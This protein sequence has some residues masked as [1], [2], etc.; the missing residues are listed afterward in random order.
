MSGLVQTGH[1]L[2]KA[3]ILSEVAADNYA[4]LLQLRSQLLLMEE[5]TVRKDESLILDII[6]DWSISQV[7][8]LCLHT[9]VFPL[10]FCLLL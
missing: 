9:V 1:F 7:V 2:V 3:F 4:Y 6:P 10:L 8:P 5:R